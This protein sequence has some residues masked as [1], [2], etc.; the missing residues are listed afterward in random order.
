[1]SEWV[2]EY[3]VCTS[4]EFSLLL[5]KP[6][7]IWWDILQ[8][9][10]RNCRLWWLM[11]RAAPLVFLMDRLGN[12][13]YFVLHTNPKLNPPRSASTFGGIWWLFGQICFERHYGCNIHLH[14]T[15]TISM[16]YL[17]LLRDWHGHC[18]IPLRDWHEHCRILSRD[19]HGH[20]RILKLGNVKTQ[21]QFTSNLILLSIAF[22]KRCTK[23]DKIFFGSLIMTFPDRM[24]VAWQFPK[25][26][27]F[28]RVIPGGSPY[29]DTA[30]CS[31]A[32]FFVFNLNKLSINSRVASDLRYLQLIWGHCQDNLIIR[33]Y[34]VHVYGELK[35][36]VFWSAQ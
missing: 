17:C 30:M 9:E 16:Q 31:F 12:M 26:G 24:A 18:R 13:S 2:A 10:M 35:F 14:K 27:L 33:K 19:W 1:M 20:C 4:L 34:Q 25:Y 28:V 15:P 36:M 3:N 29:E 21:R 8:K 11:G 23:I 32:G 7:Y 5:I 22:W 6:E